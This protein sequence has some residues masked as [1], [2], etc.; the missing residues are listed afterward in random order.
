MTE[1]WIDNKLCDLT[2]SDVIAMSYGV[3]RLTDI[4]S[5]QGY[6]SNTFG[7]TKN[8]QNLAIFGIP[9]EL[10]STD[11]TRWERL[12][13][14]IITDGVYQVFG[15]A[16]LQSV[17]GEISVVVKGGNTDWIQLLLEKK[18]SELQL[19][20]LDHKATV[21]N[22]KANRFNTYSSGYVYPDVDYGLLKD[23]DTVTARHFHLFPSV[24]MLR[25]IRQCFEDIGFTV[26]S[27]L[28]SIPK[29]QKMVLPFS[30]IQEVHSVDWETALKFKV[31][32]G[33]GQ[34]AGVPPQFGFNV[35]DMVSVTAPYF[36]NG[37]HI[38][39]AT[40]TY[41]NDEIVAAQ[42]FDIRFSLTCT[43]S[44]VFI[45]T[46]VN[47][48]A[49][50]TGTITESLALFSG[51]LA[52]G[53]TVFSQSF[54]W[55]SRGE[56][57]KVIIRGNT[58]TITITDG[59][60]ECVSVDLS[61]IRDSEWNIAANLP[62][63]L[64][65]DLIKHVVNSFNAIISKD[66]TNNL[67][68]ISLFDSIPTNDS[69]DWSN[70][71]DL[72]EEAEH[73][74]DYGDYKK[75]N[76]LEYT[77]NTGDQF[78]KD[79]KDLGKHTITTDHLDKGE[80]KLYQSP[81][82]LVQ[83]G[84]T[85]SDVTTKAKID[86]F[87]GVTGYS[88]IFVL[89]D[90]TVSSIT[91]TGLVTVTG[92]ASQLISGVGVKFSN[93]IG[94]LV[95]GANPSGGYITI[96]G[97]SFFLPSYSS[98]VSGRV[99]IVASVNS[100][101]EFQLAGIFSG[102]AITSGDAEVGVME[103]FNLGLCFNVVDIKGLVVNDLI[104]FYDTS[105]FT[106]IDSD[107]NRPTDGAELVIKN[108]LGS[109]C[110]VLK[111]PSTVTG[112][113]EYKD[114]E[115]FGGSA[116]TTGNARLIQKTESREAE[117]RI[118]IHNVATDADNAITLFDFYNAAYVETQTSELTYDEITWDVLA[119]A[120]WVTITTIIKNP[121]MIKMLMRLSASDINQ[122]DFT[123]PKWIDRFNCFFYLSYINQYK[124]NEVDSTEVELIKLP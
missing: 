84:R 9:T 53:T 124:V 62:D 8:A 96:G 108:V 46:V 25:L 38:D 22:V 88:T 76:T 122:I 49:T 71:I 107:P 87:T 78:L 105:P 1:L 5:R 123:R 101:T 121:Q 75:T 99:M 61:Y 32:I 15:F 51:T 93:L 81:F 119:A 64:Q 103:D 120:Y 6:Y 34:A 110:L 67:I 21:T 63:L 74:F 83:R 94:G 92:G 54:E 104:T 7:I 116:I 109:R 4:E 115:I 91:T 10:N 55:H 95:E 80:K 29:Y 58:E 39:L 41:D 33:N 19:A 45:V 89:P 26:I 60:L 77:N 3:N 12:E 113:G 40:D 106:L 72:T 31:E 118:A 13:C 117:P 30:N 73:T 70:K 37:G 66:T 56:S 28:D 23:C 65:T 100:D 43:T 85:L 24:F 90:M 18:L 82:S 11:T 44:T 79:Y 36:D 68:T 35:I 86:Q 16:Q 59:Y 111:Q 47:G 42:N 114:V 52:V 20:D 17:K 2:G 102:G 112:Q 48:D 27:E 98:V 14:S 57:M 69:E 97:Q 50:T